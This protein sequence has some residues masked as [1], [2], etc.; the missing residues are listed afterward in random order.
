MGGKF[1]DAKNW[2]AKTVPK[3]TDVVL[4]KGGNGKNDIEVSKATSVGDVMLMGT[5]L[6]VE[7]NVDITGNL[8][9]S[10]GGCPK[11]G[12]DAMTLVRM[13]LAKMCA[14]TGGT[15]KPPLTT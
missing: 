6:V 3:K 7:R 14:A 4:A 5:N 12:G 9:C 11:T 13:T 8:K 10:I 15:T 1:S 2:G